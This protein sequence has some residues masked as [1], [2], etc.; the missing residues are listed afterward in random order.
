M[1]SSII[2][3]TKLL[4]QLAEESKTDIDTISNELVEIAISLKHKSK[5]SSSRRDLMEKTM[6]QHIINKE[7][8]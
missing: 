3:T 8:L 6:N 7:K 4:K 5:S 2:D 1:P